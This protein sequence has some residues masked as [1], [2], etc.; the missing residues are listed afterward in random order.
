L[1]KKK[2][3]NYLP[4]PASGNLKHAMNRMGFIKKEFKIKK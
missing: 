3:K 4:A 1:Y 2:P